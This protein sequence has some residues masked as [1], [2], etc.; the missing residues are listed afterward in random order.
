[1]PGRGGDGKRIR[2][3]FYGSPVERLIDYHIKRG[4]KYGSGV[5][6]SGYGGG[7][8]GHDASGYHR[9]GQRGGSI[10]YTGGG[11]SAAAD[12][13]YNNGSDAEIVEYVRGS[14]LDAKYGTGSERRRAVFGIG[15]YILKQ[16]KR[17]GKVGNA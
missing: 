14:G 10:E 3:Y 12:I 1:M 2:S 4:V 13:L 9:N 5:E 8:A 17:R 7:G 16:A 6:G 11:L 15:R